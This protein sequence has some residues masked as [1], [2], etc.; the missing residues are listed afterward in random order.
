MTFLVSFNDTIDN[1]WECFLRYDNH[2]NQS[3][4]TI[5]SNNPF[6]FFLFWWN[7]LLLFSLNI[8][9][10]FSLFPILSYQII[11]IFSFEIEFYAWTGT[12]QSI[13]MSYDLPYY[14]IWN[15]P[16]TNARSYESCYYYLLTNKYIHTYIYI[17]IY[18]YD[19]R[20]YILVSLN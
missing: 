18:I 10:L 12:L 4:T 2:F 3:I 1:S 9:F 6:T 20:H 16:Q 15:N 11:I 17:Y 7:G 8:Q 19:G 5:R 14:H 13:T